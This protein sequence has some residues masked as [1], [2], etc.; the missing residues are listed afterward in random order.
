MI[1]VFSILAPILGNV[2]A[3]STGQA[4]SIVIGQPNFTSGTGATTASGLFRPI[5][6]VFD[7]AGNLWVPDANNNRILK[8]VPPFTN[9]M[10]TLLVIGQTSF[11]SGSAATSATGLSTPSSVAFDSAGDLWVA[12]AINSRVLEF[13]PPL[14]TG[15]A[16]SLVIGQPDFTTNTGTTTAVG[17]MNPGSLS[18]DSAGD[19]WVSDSQNF[20]VL[21]YVPP[22]A[23]HM[24]A[25]LVIGQA[26]FTS[27]VFQ[28]TASGLTA[29][30]G[31]TFDS[32]GDLWVSDNG[33]SRV[34]KFVHPFSTGM[35]ASLVIGQSSFTTG[36]SMTTA[37][38]LS[39]PSRVSFDTF[40]DLWVP[41]S[42]NNR[43]LE[44]L[45]P[46]T[47]G[48]A[49]AL[50]IGQ[51]SFTTNT[52]AVTAT[53]LDSPSALAFDSFG[54]LWVPDYFANRVLEYVGVGAHS[55]T[56]FQ[57]CD[58]FAGVG[59][60]KITWWRPDTCGIPS[61]MTF[62]GFLVAS[63]S[64]N[65]FM[66][67]M[68]FNPPGCSRGAGNPCLYAAM[69]DS[70]S[71]AVFDNTGAF[72]GTCGTGYS[73]SPE[74]VV[75][76]PLW[77]PRSP[78]IF[79][80]Q[81]DGTRQILRFS[82]DCSAGT[83]AF[84]APAVESRGSDWIDLESNL[85]TMLYTSEGTHIK[86][87]DICANAQLP[88]FATL[89]ASPAF[90]LR[91]LGDGSVLVADFSRDVHVSSTG[92]VINSC[93]TAS[94]GAGGLSSLNIVPGVSEFVSGSVTNSQVDYM[95]T[96]NCDTGKTAPDFSFSATIGTGCTG[97]C[98]LNGLI[99]FPKVTP[100]ANA[101]YPAGPQV[102]N[103]SISTF[104]GATAEFTG[105]QAGQIDLPDWPLSPAQQSSVPCATS[106]VITCSSP[107]PEKGYSGI[108][109]NLAGVF[110]GIAQ[111]Y[112]NSL[113]SIELRQGIAHLVNKTAFSDLNNP[114]CARLACMPND[115]PAPICT[116]NNGCT[117]GGLPAPN[118]CSWD[119]IFGQSSASNCLVGSPAGTA[120]NC[121]YATS[122]SCP[123][124]STTCI[125]NSACT[126]AW[127]RPIGSK[128][129]CAAAQ[130]F[131]RAFSVA[132][133]LNVTFNSSCELIPIGGWPSA[134][135]SVN[136]AGCSGAVATANVC[137]FA[138]SDDPLRLALGQ[139]LAQEICALFSPA[140]TG[141]VGWTTLPASQL[142]C[143]NTNIGLG[144]NVGFLQL[145]TGGAG[146]FCGLA[147]SSTGIPNNCWG[148][149]TRDFVND[150]PFDR[151]I[152][153][154]YNSLFSTQTTVTCTNSVCTGSTPGSP[155]TS[156][157]FSTRA[158]D[159]MYV[160]SPTY[161]SLSTAMEFSACL[162]SPGP[163]TGPIPPQPVPTFANC[164][165]SSV[166]GGVGAITCVTAIPVCDAVSAGYQAEDYFGARLF[167]LPVYSSV[168]V[169]GRLANWP[170]GSVASPGVLNAIGGAYDPLPNIFT[171][172]NAYSSTPNITAVRQ[173]FEQT[174]RSLNPFVAE[175]PQDF[176]VLDN[177]YNTLF[178]QNPLCNNS[179]NLA[180]AAGGLS[181]AG[182]SQCSSI[183]QNI[184]WM[185]TSHSF[186]CYPGGPA[187]TP[188]TLGYG[189]ST[190]FANTSADLR[191][192]L[193][194]GNH[195]QDNGPVTAWDVKYSFMDLDATGAF[196]ATSLA[197]IVHINVIDEFTV[198]LNLKAKGP[199]TEFFIGG[200][201]IIPGHVWSACGASIWNTG[202]TGKN[203]AGTSVVTAP[204]DTCV[205]TF[206]APSIATVGGV[207]ADSPT[208]SVIG[209]NFLIGSGP[210]TCQSIGGTGH[211]AVGTLGGGCSI[212]NT[213]TPAFGLGVY[214]LTRTG[215]TLTATG[216]TCG[217]AGSSSDYFH[218]SGA[219]AAY[220]WTGDIGSGSAD[221]N[222]LL[223][224]NSCHS[225]TP[226]ANCPHWA[227]G[228]G[229]PGGTGTNPV[230]LST[231]LKV[232][233]F[234]G[235]S[236]IGFSTE[237][238]AGTQL[239]LTCEP[240]Y[241][242]PGTTLTPC[243]A[244]NAGWTGTVLPGIG[245]Y[246]TTLYE[247]GSQITIGT[248]TTSTS[249][250]APAMPPGG[251][252]GAYTN[253]APP[254]GTGTAYPNGG[255]DC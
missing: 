118:P 114:L 11:T 228:I 192:S 19:L 86:S 136:T 159:Y 33:N 95:T 178:V 214:T 20:R 220:V 25:S 5:G 40:G 164:S 88:D 26:D 128:D 120:Y 168:Y 45:A 186:L 233:S 22:F 251:P 50:V 143:D 142:S 56:S 185:T 149:Y 163:A 55:N 82:L 158:N 115:N 246:A 21:E 105:L 69:F 184:D 77:G 76:A 78:A 63:T 110:W 234:K 179:R 31:A 206:A 44:Y 104:N 122:L 30:E 7:S 161:D 195:W 29:P 204:E 205:G 113:A 62:E 48:M 92:A 213:D 242:L 34:L 130:H 243:S 74:S 126:F 200:I 191:L 197:D 237:K 156:S 162:V 28:T 87:F 68:S 154:A 94:A 236:W 67:G 229:N 188:T 141:G 58:V 196:Q 198:D 203:T 171:W 12:D 65:T 127:Q 99:V 83:P 80:G 230:G 152:Y 157:T 239:I 81:A 153:Y 139:S 187:C 249:T 3:F 107:V 182:L 2:H 14:S 210:Y 174:P 245:G 165:G 98:Q 85:C 72:L 216:T 47:T 39:F 199:F 226:S 16:A 148:M 38:G 117:N 140:W 100:Q 53:G 101:W 144:P 133:A 10:N 247:V 231:R 37:T 1:A 13:V 131:A 70:N 66:T 169:Y 241:T 207:R 124:A 59:S 167:A 201:T 224:V 155:C 193:N 177:I 57:P 71:L 112:G 250:L 218:S 172:L 189:N 215:C 183:L 61:S 64:A 255:T 254:I 211:P 235:V 221:F 217:V 202:V 253:C 208:F 91:I 54:N 176:Y 232:S 240:G 23:T 8:Y 129:F 90:A 43:V 219:L 9:G 15:M 27:R 51:T 75:V 79:V 173:G 252:N 223:T 108:E 73:A 134:A 102:Q 93:D 145:A 35:A 248:A 97:T 36:T 111:N 138:R 4:A 222:K 106:T 96:A 160:C 166:P 109:F 84:F 238:T 244:V 17:L 103:L 146:A 119:T 175:T 18:F 89:P 49:A 181:A 42:S 116:V 32:S 151:S 121:A 170:L 209:N 125:G 132:L 135:T 137:F 6:A 60:G 190:Y 46:F 123:G 227:Q 52:V 41:D 180:T 147:T 225:A 150:Y 212:D 194:R 24:A